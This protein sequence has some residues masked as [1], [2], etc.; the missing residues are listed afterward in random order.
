[1]KIVCALSNFLPLLLHL[2]RVNPRLSS[3][4]LLSLTRRG[5]LSLLLL[6]LPPGPHRPPF[7]RAAR[8][9]DGG[10]QSPSALFQSRTRKRAAPTLPPLRFSSVQATPQ[11]PSSFSHLDNLS[12]HFPSPSLSLSFHPTLGRSRSVE[13]GVVSGFEK[14]SHDSHRAFVP[15][16]NSKQIEGGCVHD[17]I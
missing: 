14:R 1:M 17:Q 8:L 4:E 2:S 11:L 15:L 9:K 12:H 10:T 6:P 7:P 5:S 13:V 16:R 3:S